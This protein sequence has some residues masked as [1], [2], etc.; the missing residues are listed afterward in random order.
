M[1]MF[2]VLISFQHEPSSN[3]SGGKGLTLQLMSS[4]VRG[5]WSD[6]TIV[7]PGDDGHKS[8]GN[9]QYTS[10]VRFR[11]VVVHYS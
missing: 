4:H 5:P 8:C 6:S 9:P 10:E 11:T 2:V 3:A 7:S 1:V